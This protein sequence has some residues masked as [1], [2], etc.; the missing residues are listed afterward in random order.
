MMLPYQLKAEV[1]GKIEAHVGNKI[2]TSYDI[3]GLDPATYKKLLSIPD[4]ET[5]NIQLEQYKS[6]VLNFLIE[7]VI[8]E[9]A[10]ERE[11]IKVTDAEI[12]RAVSEIAA[13]NKVSLE[14]F[15]KM[16]AD[17]GLSLTQYR[18]QI[19]GQIIQARIRS[20]IC[21]PQVAITEEDI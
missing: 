10:A 15:E 16:I 14:Q 4:E 21:M 7:A 6:Q 1:I 12:D 9:T 3:E 20:Q 17:E 11:G 2:I 5:R 18:Y 13:N 8:M 19:K